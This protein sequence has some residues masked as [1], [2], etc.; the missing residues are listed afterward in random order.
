MNDIT[1]KEANEILSHYTDLGYG[2]VIE[3][4]DT[5]KIKQALSLASKTLTNGT[6]L[7]INVPSANCISREALKD[8]TYINK[9]NF[10]TVEGI[11]A[12]IDNA[13]AVEPDITNDDLQAAMTESYHLG[14]GLAETKFKRPQGVWECHSDDYMVF[15]TCSK[16][17]SYGY[18]RDKFCKHCGAEMQTKENDNGVANKNS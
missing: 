8:I 2:V 3:G 16:C 14:Y 6:P 9:G 4:E 11:R 13:P 17:N 7:Y 10:N 15:Y 1:P 18:I 12:W 5:S